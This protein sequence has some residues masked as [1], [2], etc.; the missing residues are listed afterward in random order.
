MQAQTAIDPLCGP[1]LGGGTGWPSFAGRM[2]ELARAADPASD[3]QL[4]FVGALLGR[5]RHRRR[6]GGAARMLDGDDPET[7]G[8]P[9]LVV[10]TDLRWSIVTALATAVPWTPIPTA[11]RSSTDE[12]RRDNTAA[13]RPK[14]ETA[15]AARPL[16]EAKDTP[17]SG[18]RGR[19]PVEHGRPSG[20]RGLRPAGPGAPAEP[21]VE[22][23]STRSPTCGDAAPARS[24]RA[25][26]IGL[27]PQWAI[28]DDAL[29]RADEFLSATTRPRLR[30]SSSRV[31]TPWPVTADPP[32][33]PLRHP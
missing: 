11:P 4:A 31:A 20:D 2:L 15:R 29:A 3:H 24:P 9:G 10:D 18:R 5:P 25:V 32:R 23:T 6:R 27:Y 26:V 30:A 14:A 12:A 21:Y 28:D 7:V 17:G 1:G 19:L 13:G 33:R 22:S 16:A 8:L